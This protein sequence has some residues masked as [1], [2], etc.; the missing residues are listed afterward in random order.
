MDV[1]DTHTCRTSMLRWLRVRTIESAPTAV[2]RRQ[3]RLALVGATTLALVATLLLTADAALAAE[4]GVEPTGV[5][6]VSSGP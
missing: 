6:D 1:K 2:S 3:L 4:I 5:G